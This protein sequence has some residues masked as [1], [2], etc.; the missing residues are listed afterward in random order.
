MSLPIGQ[1]LRQTRQARE[2]SLEQVSKAT[3]IRPHYLQALEAGDFEALPSPLQARGFLRL[4]A[5]YLGLDSA[6]MLAVLRPAASPAEV[7]SPAG[8]RLNPPTRPRPAEAASPG[9]SSPAT[10]PDA[11]F[12]AMAEPLGVAAAEPP[13][14]QSSPLPAELAQAQQ[15][16][17]D[18]GRRLRRQ[19]ELL[20]LTL[21]EVARHTKLRV[22]Y[23]QALEAGQV[24]ALPSSVQ[25]RGM[26]KNY[27]AFVGLDPEPLLLAFADALQLRLAARQPERPAQ[28]LNPPTQPRPAPAGVGWLRRWLSPDLFWIV[29]VV[30]ALTAFVT[31]GVGQVLSTT[32]SVTPV[33]SAPSIAEVLGAESTPTLASAVAETPQPVQTQP[34]AGVATEAG[35]FTELTPVEPGNQIPQLEGALQVYVTVRQRAWLRVDVDG[36]VAYEGI[37]LPGAAL[38]FS[39]ETRLELR[40]GN[41][42]ALQVYFNRQDLGPLG[43]FGEAVVRVFTSEGVLL[44]T[45]TITPTSPPAPQVTPITPP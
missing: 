37:V 19:R 6:P 16:L 12:N 21:D 44:P 4:Y 35:E 43:Q 29:L 36:D 3:R 33:P 31:W 28:N 27:A 7:A 13:A 25:G 22:H 45:P 14:D 40:T 42:A 39:G 30:A 41:A 26:L 15:R 9:Q 34:P 18:I 32:A 8:S 11:W 5:E 1:Q 24:D 2:L 23:L 17:D 38:P 20:G 10:D